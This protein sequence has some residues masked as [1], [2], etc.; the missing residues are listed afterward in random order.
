MALAGSPTALLAW[1]VEKLHDWTDDYRG[2]EDELL[3]WVSIYWF[4]TA[5]PAA[6]VR[7]YYEANHSGGFLSSYAT[8]MGAQREMGMF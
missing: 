8:T 4:F 7:I 3:T 2:T 1:I 6:S 5:G